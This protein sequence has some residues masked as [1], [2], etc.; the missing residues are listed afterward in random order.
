[1]KR[2]TR[3]TEKDHILDVYKDYKNEDL[4]DDFDY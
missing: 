2:I 4:N 3:L 1:M